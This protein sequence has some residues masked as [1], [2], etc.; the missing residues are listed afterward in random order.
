VAEDGT[1]GVTVTCAN[2]G[3]T[4]GIL[5]VVSGQFSPTVPGGIPQYDFSAKRFVDVYFPANSKAEKLADEFKSPFGQADQY[6]YGYIEYIDIFKERHMSK[7][8]YK[9]YPELRKCELIG[10][11]AWSDW[12]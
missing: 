1:V 6:F 3:R 10:A 2:P 4:L 8:C 9:I 12:D 7:F 11:A 5:L